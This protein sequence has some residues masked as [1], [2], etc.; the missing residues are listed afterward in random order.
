M[1][2]GKTI[3]QL[4][5]L[6]QITEDTSLPVEL[7][8]GTYHIQYSAI[9]DNIRQQG[10]RTTASGVGS[11]TEGAGFEIFGNPFYTSGITYF[12]MDLITQGYSSVI[13]SGT[14]NTFV[15][16]GDSSYITPGIIAYMYLADV[17]NS[18]NVNHFYYGDFVLTDVTYDG[19]SDKTTFTISPSLPEVMYD[20]QGNGLNALGDYSHAEGLST[21]AIGNYSHAEGTYTNAGIYGWYSNSIVDG[22]ITIENLPYY[23]D[24]FTFQNEFG[25]EYVFLEDRQFAD[26]FG[27]DYFEYTNIENLNGSTIITLK[28][29]EFTSTELLVGTSNVTDYKFVSLKYQ[30]SEGFDNFAAGANSHAEGLFS[31]SLGEGS[32]SEG[33]STYTYGYASHAEGDNTSAYGQYSHSEGSNTNAFGYTSHAEGTS[34]YSIGNNSHSEGN[35]TFSGVYGF[36]SNNINNGIIVIYNKDLTSVFY[37]GTKIIFDDRVYSNQS[38]LIQTTVSASTYNTG[39]THTTIYCDNRQFSSGYGRIVL[40]DN[41]TPFGSDSTFGSGSHAEGSNTATYGVGSHTEGIG[42]YAI[43]DYQTVIGTF[44]KI[45]GDSLFIVGNGTYQNNRRNAMEVK[46]D[47][48][49]ITNKLNVPAGSNL[50]LSAGKPSATGETGNII[51]IF[52]EDGDRTGEGGDIYLWAGWGGDAN[53]SG[54]GDLI[55]GGGDIKIR[56]G[57]GGQTNNNVHTGNNVAGGTVK[58][59]GGY[60]QTSYDIFRADGGWVLVNGGESN[61]GNGG[62]VQIKGG[63]GGNQGNLLNITEITLSNPVQ[64]T[65]SGNSQLIN[66]DKV[67]ILDIVGTTEL[68]DNSYYISNVNSSKFS[69]YL[70][71]ELSISVDGSGMTTYV[72]GGISLLQRNG[73][74]VNIS[75]GD[76]R[77][78]DGDMGT[79]NID[80]YEVNIET[81]LNISGPTTIN[82]DLT[83][84]GDLVITGSA[85]AHD[86][87]ITGSFDVPNQLSTF[88]NVI[89]SGNLT[90]TGTTNG[91]K[92]YVAILNQTGSNPPTANVLENT[93]GFD[94]DWSYDSTGVYFATLQSGSF[95]YNK[96]FL[97]ITNGYYSAPYTIYAGVYE[98][99][100]TSLIV[101]SFDL[102]GDNMEIEGTAFIEI[103]QYP[104]TPIPSGLKLTFNSI[105]NANSLVGGADN[106]ENW[107]TF[108]D[109]PTNGT[110]F[111]GV[112]LYGRN[113]YLYGGE[114][115]N[116]KPNL[117]NENHNIIKVDDEVGCVVYVDDS[118]FYDCYSILS[119]NLPSVTGIS[120]YSFYYCISMTGITMPN[121]IE[122]GASAFE[123]CNEL[124]K[125]D[126]PNLISLGDYSFYD[127]NSIVEFNLPNLLIAGIDCFD[128]CYAATGFTFPNMIYAGSSCFYDCEGSTIFDLPSLTGC[129]DSCFSSCIS[130]TTFNLPSLI[131]L[132]GD[133][134]DNSVFYGIIGNNITINVPSELLTCNFGLPDGDLIYLGL[135]NTLILNGNPYQTLSGYTGNLTLEWDN[136]SNVP[137][138]DASSVNDWNS[139]FDLP[140]TSTPFSSVTVDG[141]SVIL[142]GGENIYLKYSLFYSV[143]NSLVSVL[144]EGCVGYVGNNCFN[145]AG[146]LTGVTLPNVIIIGDGSF[147]GTNI[148]TLSM[149][150]LIFADND[151]LSVGSIISQIDLP[152]LK[153]AGSYCFYQCSSITGFTLPNLVIAKNNC[154][155]GCSSVLDYSL[156]S[157]VSAENACFVGSNSSTINLPSLTG[158]GDSCFYICNSVTEFTLDNLVTA[159]ANCFQGCSSVTGFTANNLTSIGYSCFKDCSSISSFVLPS[160]T[161]AGDL[162]FMNCTSLTSFTA[163]NL[164]SAGDAFFEND[165]NITEFNLD[166]LQNAGSFCFAFNP[167]IQEFNL[168]SL[169][170]ISTSCFYGCSSIT[171]F[172]APNLEYASQTAFVGCTSMTTFNLPS[173]TYAEIQ[174]F[175][176]CSSTTQFNLPNLITASYSTFLDCISA[177]GFTLTNLVTAGPSCF[178]G[179]NSV[180][181]FNLP[182][183]TGA[184]N[185]SFYSCTSMTAITAD[186]LTSVGDYSFYDCGSLLS[187]NLPSVTYVGQEAFELDES[188]QTVNL[189]LAEY[190]GYAAFYDCISVT[191]FY[192]PSV[193]DLGGGGCDIDDQVFGDINGNTINLTISPTLLT[194]NS[195]G[196]DADIQYLTSNN[197]VTIN[198]VPP[199]SLSLIFDNITNVNSFVG[200]SSNVTDWNTFFGLPSY[201]SPFT[202][203]T[204]IGNEVKLF[205]GGNITVK[206]NL[207]GGTPGNSLGEHLLS[208]VD[209]NGVITE[210]EYNA[211]GGDQNSNIITTM[212]DLPAAVIIGEGAFC[213]NP[214]LTSVNLPSA[215]TFSTAGTG[216]FEVC[217]GLTTISLPSAT[218]IGNYCFNGCTGLTNI[219]LSACTNLGSSVLDNVVFF[220]IIGN[221]ITLTVPSALMTCNSGNPDGDIQFLQSNDTVTVITV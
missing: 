10:F 168:P 32:H 41:K 194:C 181:N 197:T 176:D 209:E 146:L 66:G 220:N 141:N 11:H 60:S 6:N 171:G 123:S 21:H 27:W 175:Q 204:V 221:T 91:I 163:N 111:T 80:G 57:R 162:G 191:D 43:S 199:S 147:A 56:G 178:E 174:C 42:T 136:I 139:F 19:G 40:P 144:D 29:T 180:L 119:I 133:T 207:F 215:T 72:S 131:D 182:S 135:F 94:I 15:V 23:P 22:I 193:T 8:G 130:A 84:N 38:G 156:P 48:V 214:N 102:N 186:N 185:N 211:F 78:T 155:E 169:T 150:N 39:T 44:N 165:T 114:N 107:N 67:F 148:T 120:N 4:E 177:T 113:V 149:P 157:L 167:V 203:V 101:E 99:D 2:T 63:I 17:F 140:I 110:P 126:F 179:C 59:E 85:S 195:G 210:L 129:G 160:L 74:D 71:K 68:N 134:G 122:A 108:F 172:T 205:G 170:G 98:T 189:P 109:L 76:A 118:A 64:I 198:G 106:V 153:Y 82:N 31:L 65:V 127:C 128:Y 47:T 69:L 9:T 90:V 173:L 16:N 87:T 95:N 73:G 164:I 77:G 24:I 166:S 151:S 105:S 1:L 26:D 116:I 14:P 45:D 112:T 142:E 20:V 92:N 86:V 12:Y 218:S 75:G 213:Y 81:E 190:I 188:I 70:D 25:V 54:R 46:T 208:I 187:V 33:N 145:I 115:I 184:G 88:T 152:N 50:T 159:G 103:K 201:G 117:F 36:T 89:I 18:I 100:D 37:P 158:A 104:S 161:T 79:V 138:G 83:I 5:F 58:I 55:G 200:N 3:S 35:Y 217:N 61:Y 202:S 93:F 96:T 154:F 62:Y 121:L 51:Q 30:H 206:Q 216:C 219:S 34:T 132:G 143:N 28:D 7:S 52:G 192:L 137:V 125:I 53:G 124:T 196:P 97:N 13:V 49:T 183:V 212:V